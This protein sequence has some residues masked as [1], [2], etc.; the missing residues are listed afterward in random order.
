MSLL[1]AI[2]AAEL[3]VRLFADTRLTAE[4][5]ANEPT[6]HEPDPVLG[7]RSKPGHYEYPGY[8]PDAPPIRMTFLPGSRRTAG[9]TPPAGAPRVLLT[10]CSYTEGWAISDEDT[11]AWQLQQRFPSV[12]IV[13]CGVGGYGTYQSLLV[14]ERFLDATSPPPRLVVYGMMDLHP[15]RNIAAWWWLR[16]LTRQ[17]QRG[18][19]ELPYCTLDR[20]GTLVRHAPEAYPQWPLRRKLALVRFAEDTYM[21]LACRRRSGQRHDVTQQ[22]LLEMKR[23]CDRRGTAFLVALLYFG[24]DSEKARYTAFMEKNGIAY[25]DCVHPKTRDMEVAG[26][27]HPNGRMNR[28]WADDLAPALQPLATPP[29]SRE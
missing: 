29:A 6:T 26:E 21:R 19:I 20:Q 2:A 9:P 16:G 17:T 12:E 23:L 7:W 8:T 10:G 25:R 22:L 11:Y 15:S 5:Y 18:H 28:L 4:V 3:L 1:I 24:D 13:N 14:I 27:G